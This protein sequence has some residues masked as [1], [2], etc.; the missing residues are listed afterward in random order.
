MSKDFDLKDFD[1]KDFDLEDVRNPD[2][3][4]KEQLR[5]PNY[6]ANY[7]TE[8]DYPETTD[9]EISKILKKS[10]EEFELAEEQKIKEMIMKE[11]NSRIEK[12]NVIKQ[13][14][15]KVQGF[16]T[17]NKSIYN[18]IIP[19]FELY[20]ANTIDSYAL[21]QKDYINVFRLLNTIRLTKEEQE[22][23]H[24]LIYPP[25]TPLRI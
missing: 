9:A 17:T 23:I 16:D 5:E 21:D 4:I 10:L 24:E 15:Q 19:I 3:V 11:R 22:L 1:L 20:A 14:L 8:H 12:Y 25:F 7:N 13:K 18:I 6:N 2:P